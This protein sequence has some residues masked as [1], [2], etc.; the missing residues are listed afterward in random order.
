MPISQHPDLISPDWPAPQRVRA[1]STS[2]SGGVSGPPLASL[3]LAGHVGDATEKVA[4]NR[5]RLKQAL[6][7]PAEPVWL[8]QVHGTRVVDAAGIGTS[9]YVNGTPEADGSY[10]RETGIVCAVLTADCLPLLLCDE[11]GSRVAAVHVGWRGLAAGVIEETLQHLGDTRQLMA[12]L[13]PAIGP[14]SFEV[15]SEVREIF[16]AHDAEANHAFRPSPAGRWLADL[17]RL[18]RQRL[19]AQGVTRIYGGGWC[20]YSESQRFYSYRRDGVTGRMATLIWL[21]TDTR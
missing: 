15:G 5:A 11:Q 17:Y 6:D 13:G 8:K 19:N 7:L 21:E 4:E 9:L 2:R 16:V 14:Y 10:S 18:T 20:T 1:C 3:N 12:W